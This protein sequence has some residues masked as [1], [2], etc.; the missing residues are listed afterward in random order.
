MVHKTWN[1]EHSYADADSIVHVQARAFLT[2]PV[3]LGPI[4]STP[5]PE[6]SAMSVCKTIEPE[7]LRGLSEGQIR[8]FTIATCTLRLHPCGPETDQA[9]SRDKC[10]VDGWPQLIILGCEE[11]KAYERGC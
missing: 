1:D 10:K 11:F 7:A 5:G 6:I 4:T 9:F 2:L 3:F 8:Q